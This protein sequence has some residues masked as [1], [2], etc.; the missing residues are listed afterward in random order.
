[1]ADYMRNHGYDL[2]Y[3]LQQN[4]ARTGPKLAGKI[5]IF[6][7][8]M[9]NYYLNLAVYQMEDFLKS[10][11]NPYYGGSFVYGR[12]MKGHGWSPM[13]NAQLVRS[14]ARYVV[15]H[16]PKGEDTATWHYR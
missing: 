15:K 9:D 6:V 5:H 2:R 12:P 3:Y 13:D 7:G 16:A 8:D 10:T 11:K 4:W 14:M 1:V